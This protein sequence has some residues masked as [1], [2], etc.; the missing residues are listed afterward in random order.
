[1]ITSK[2]GENVLSFQYEYYSNGFIK[3]ETDNSGETSYVYDKVGWLTNV[4]YTNGDVE[5]Y[6]YDKSDNR[7]SKT[8]NGRIMEYSYD[9]NNRLYWIKK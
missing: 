9:T 7:I 8:L 6:A 2:N 4:N 3:S 5:S 1:M